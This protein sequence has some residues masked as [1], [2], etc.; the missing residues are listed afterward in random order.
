[1]AQTTEEGK[2]FADRFTEDEVQLFER[3]GFIIVRGMGDVDLCGNMLK[4]TLEDLARETEPIEFETDVHY[5]GSPESL[6]SEGGRTVR[7]LKQAHSRGTVFTDWLSN[8]GLC[9]RL[10]QILGPDVVMPLAHH[11]CIMTK[12]PRYS[13][14]T[15]WHRDIRY[16]SYQRPELVSVWLALGQ[17][18]SENGGLLVIPGTHKMEFQPNQF[19]AAEFLRSDVAE[20]QPVI[21]TQ[22][23]AE[24]N[25]GD[26]LF[27]HANLFHA[28]TRNY[29]DQ[30]KFS[31]V[32]SFRPADNPPISGTRSASLPELIVPSVP[33]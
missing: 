24:L 28:A 12:H 33:D 4:S 25:P 7:R 22:V 15:G 20:N 21:E 32:L 1:M 19:D 16:W 2:T 3:D 11:N 9:R 31:V 30:T 27:F 6:N 14:D 13:S 5:P 8:P 17:E 18:F 10:A 23:Y 29:T 26:V